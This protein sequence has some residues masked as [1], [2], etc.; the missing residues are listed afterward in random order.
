MCERLLFLVGR[1]TS[2]TRGNPRVCV[3]RPLYPFLGFKLTAEIN[4]L[5]VVEYFLLGI[6]PTSD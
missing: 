5:R 4:K 3:Q 6:T 1:V 2:S